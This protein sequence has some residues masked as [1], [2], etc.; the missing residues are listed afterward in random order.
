[1]KAVDEM[2]PEHILVT[3]VGRHQMFAAL[4][5]SVSS[6][7]TFVT[8][9]GLGTMGFGLP[10]AI[11]VKAG[12]PD[13]PVVVIAGDGSF[14]MTCQE[15]ATAVSADL[16]VIA[17]VMNDASLGMIKQLQDEFYDKSFDASMFDTFIRYDKLSES[18]GGAGYRVENADE[19]KKVLEKALQNKQITV[20]DCIIKEDAH[21]YPMV[22]GK[23]LL[24]QVK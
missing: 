24:D 13:T 11:G 21:V 9:G 1:L 12:K 14:T 17:L 5:S 8:S 2:I 15:I 19:L 10:A 18:L 4:Y 23:N 7:R 20:I 16:P 6:G 3:D 22:T